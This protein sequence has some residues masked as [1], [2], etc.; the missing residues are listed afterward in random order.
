MQKGNVR[1]QRTIGLDCDKT[2]LCPEALFLRRDDFEVLRIDFGNHHRYVRGKAVSGIIRNYGNFPL[3][4]AL[5]ERFYLCF[6]HIDGTK[7]KIDFFRYGI[8]VLFRVENSHGNI[9]FGNGTIERPF[10]LDCFPVS[11][12]GRTTGRCQS[13]N[14]EKRVIFEQKEEALSH[15]SRSADDTGIVLFHKNLLGMFE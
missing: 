10:V 4:I 8:R 7:D 3:C 14:L 12:S 13:R 6:I 11:F 9:F 2:L 15:H 1:L 5:F